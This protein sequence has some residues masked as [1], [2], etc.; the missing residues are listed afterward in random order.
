MIKEKLSLVPMLPGCYLMKNK[1]G[2]IIYVGKAKILKRRLNSYFNRTQT[3]KTKKLVS[4]IV[5]FD[6]IVT[7]SELE[8]FILEINLIK[9]YDPKYN[10]LLK[11]DKSYPYIE[12]KNDKYPT[13]TVKREINI[14]KKN[15]M[16]FGPYPNVGAARRI[17]NLINRL[18]PLKKCDKMPKKECL[19]YHIGECLGYCVFKDLDTTDLRNEITLILNGHDDILINKINEK[20]KVNSDNLNYEV[21]LELKNELDYIK[22]VFEKQKVELNDGINRD[23]FNYYYEN[24]YISIV[25]FFLRNGKLVGNKKNIFPLIDEI[26]DTM[27]YYIVNFYQKKNIPPKE[28]IVPE[29]LDI[30]LLNSLLDSKVV[31]A[32]KGKKKHLFDLAKTNAKINLDNN[33]EMEYRK[34]ERSFDASREL[35][36]IVGIDNL[37]V[38]ES[39]DNSNLFG[40]FTVSGMVTFIDGVPSKKDYRKFKISK[41]QNDD[42]GSMKEVIYRR[43]QSVLMNNSKKPDLIL[44]DGGI[45][46]I[47]ACKSVLNDLNLNIKVCG[48]MKDDKHTLS[49]L[50]DGDTL[51]SYKIDK[52]SNVF[53]LL[54]RISDEVHRFTINYHRQIRS[55]GSISSVLDNIEGI[56]PTR[57]KEL[58][59]KFGS[60]KKIKEATL[61]ELETILPSEVAKNTLEYLNE[62]EKENINDRN[63]DN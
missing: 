34:N 21:A 19:Y 50:I 56:G 53:Y 36:N 2:T 22:V 31:T 41:E 28:I 49:E 32:I 61:E 57:K 58:L 59:K 12:F 27:E 7:S 23:I 55:K 20:I 47:N 38:I 29:E 62:F 1:D 44:V 43:Y 40:S 54:T 4:E 48:L 35:G 15:K 45:N 5:D 42:V 3:G 60:L 14:N 26:N 25:V 37:S 16:L 13:L 30:E 24:G 11:D 10:I 17:V 52:K 51:N 63:S 6:Y 8:A 18:Y 33:I 46:Q 39:F 9:K